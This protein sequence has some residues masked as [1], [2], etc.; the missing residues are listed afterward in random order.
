[1]GRAGVRPRRRRTNT[2]QRRTGGVYSRHPLL[3]CVGIDRTFYG[4]ISAAEFLRYAQQVP[5]DFRF[6]VKA[7]ML[8]TATT[9]RG[10]PGM[11]SATNPRFLD[12]GFA[13]EHFVGPW[14]S[15]RITA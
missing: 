2:G 9:I 4:P 15:V 7:P 13:V 5:A 10:E 12:A 14:T 8:C 3:R 11:R 1:M 6:V